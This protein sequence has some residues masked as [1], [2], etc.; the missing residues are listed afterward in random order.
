M[1]IDS[2]SLF[3]TERQQ[4][5]DTNYELRIRQGQSVQFWDDLV[6]ENMYAQ[7]LR[8]GNRYF[9]D[10]GPT[11]RSVPK[12]VAT[13]NYQL[14]P[15]CWYF[16]SYQQGHGWFQPLMYDVFTQRFDP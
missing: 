9:E 11:M 12:V 7:I 16:V 3:D 6:M 2:H 8:H 15:E 1:R 4:V 5:V 14:E 13:F 10:H